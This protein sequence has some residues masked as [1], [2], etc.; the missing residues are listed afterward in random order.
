MTHKHF[1]SEWVQAAAAAAH[2]ANRAYCRF[3]GDFSEFHWERIPDWQR[4]SVLLGV[5]NAAYR[6]DPPTPEESHNCWMRHKKDTGWVWGPKKDE[7][8]KEHPALV[9]YSDL[10]PE[11]KKKDQLFLAVVRAFVEIAENASEPVP[12]QES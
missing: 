4:E 7:E 8:K 5:L 12:P 2:E 9:P 1:S 6:R 3:L 10:P 11:W